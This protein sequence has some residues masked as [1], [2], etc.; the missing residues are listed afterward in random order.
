MQRDVTGG[1]SVGSFEKQAI[2]AR[3]AG[4]FQLLAALNGRV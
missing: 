3:F 4:G 2:G 1:P